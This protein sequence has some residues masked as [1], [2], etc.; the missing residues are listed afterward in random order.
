METKPFFQS[1]L[2]FGQGAASAFF[3]DSRGRRSGPPGTSRW[4]PTTRCPPPRRAGTA[5]RRIGQ[6]HP[7]AQGDHGQRH[8][9]PGPAQ[10]PVQAVQQEQAARCRS[11]RPPRCAGTGRPPA[12]MAVSVPSTNRAIRGRAKIHTRAEIATE[13]TTAV[14]TA[15]FSPFRMRSS[16]PRAVVLGDEG[17]EGVAEVLDRQIGEGVDLH[18]GGE[19]RHHRVPEAVDQTLD[20][21]DAQV[22]HRLLDAGEEGEAADL[23]DPGPADRAVPPPGPQAGAADQGD[24]P[25]VPGRRRTG[26]SPWPPPPRPPPGPGPG[27][28][29]GPGRC[30]A[31]RRPPGRAGAS[32]S[33]PPPAGS[34]RS[35]CTGTCRRCP[36]RSP[37]GTPAS[38]PRWLRRTPGEQAWMPSRHRKAARFSAT[39]SPAMRTK[40]ARALSRSP[41]RP[42]GRS[43]WRR[44][45]RCPC[46]APAGWR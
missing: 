40:E 43:G 4:A 42:A 8:A 32:P 36:R 9:H 14:R 26:R 5:E 44:P 33:P 17:G 11:R 35:S 22:H 13:N 29:T 12:M 3:S 28:T 2:K 31:R 10:G 34:R 37:P 15:P 20:H 6:G 23:P 41:P 25:P 46:T 19:G 45:P 21:E 16:L 1:S 30:S 39:V 18:P 27:R 38:A 24:E 7:G